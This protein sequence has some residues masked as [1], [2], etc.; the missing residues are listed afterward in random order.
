M[1]RRDVCDHR[2]A[3]LPDWVCPSVVEAKLSANP[4]ATVARVAA[5]YRR[6]GRVIDA[7]IV[8]SQAAAFGLTARPS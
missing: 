1:S 5:E 2:R 8:E 7:G 4:A 3:G 6:A